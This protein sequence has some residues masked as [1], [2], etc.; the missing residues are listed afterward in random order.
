MIYIASP[1]SHYD[2]K[3]RK[4][5]YDAVNCFCGHLF[6]SQGLFVYSP[7]VHWHPIAVER[8]WTGCFEQ[9]RANDFHMLT[10]ASEMYL[11]CLDGWEDSFG[12]R[13]ELRFCRSLKKPVTIFD[14]S[15]QETNELWPL[16][17]RQGH[18]C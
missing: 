11:L 17:P 8:E 4:Q 5:R 14:T 18:C 1:Y 6:E 10:L 3:T 16:S 12:V 13:Q 7:I 9:F 15:Y 2:T